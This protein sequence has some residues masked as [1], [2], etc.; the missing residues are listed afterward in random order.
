MPKKAKRSA[1]ATPYNDSIRK[2]DVAQDIKTMHDR[3]MAVLTTYPA[4]RSSDRLLIAEVYRRYYY[5]CKEPF[6]VV[7]SMKELPNGEKLPSF[8][9]IRRCRQKIQEEH[10]ELRAV[11]PVEKERINRQSDFID[12]ARGNA[13]V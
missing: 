7:M 5:I 10:E 12:Y 4:S 1:E 3:V 11:A 13:Y 9:T 2:T 6:Y 8:E